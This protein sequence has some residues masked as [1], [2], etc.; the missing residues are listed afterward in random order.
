M[1]DLRHRIRVHLANRYHYSHAEFCT[2]LEE[3]MQES[4]P[5]TSQAESWVPDME[6]VANEWADGLC[7]AR[8]GLSNIRD[9]I[10]TVDAL[11][12]RVDDSIKHCREVRAR[13]EAAQI[14]TSPTIPFVPWSKE[15]EMW[16]S[17][18]AHNISPEKMVTPYISQT[19]FD[20]TFSDVV[21]PARRILFGGTKPLGDALREQMLSTAVNSV[22]KDE[23]APDT[24]SVYARLAA[25]E[26][27]AE[28][29]ESQFKMQS[30]IT[31]S[32]LELLASAMEQLTNLA[33]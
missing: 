8:V 28:Q 14:A 16:E 10:E 3:L 17:W 30:R 4:E 22:C 20:K 21:A 6:H 33:G 23:A 26:L 27:R 25:S 13:W 18:T 1:N 7:D 2:K 9:G 31:S 15:A 19:Q 11:I 32:T 29:L 5:S 12:N 24:N